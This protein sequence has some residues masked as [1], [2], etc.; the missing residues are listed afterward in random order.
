MLRGPFA[1]MIRRDT[2]L[3][4][5][6]ELLH[7]CSNIVATKIL[8]ANI[9]LINKE[10]QFQ[11]NYWLKWCFPWSF[12]VTPF[13]RKNVLLGMEVVNA[14]LTTIFL[15]KEELVFQNCTCKA[16][17]ASCTCQRAKNCT[18]LHVHE[19]IVY[20]VIPIFIKLRSRN[21][22][23]KYAEFISFVKAWSINTCAN[24]HDDAQTCTQITKLKIILA[25]F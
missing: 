13:T 1:T 17:R 7:H 25:Q 4:H 11:S 3:H 16:K 14:N 21:I 23:V 12:R 6:F 24:T 19:L 5:C 8:V 20:Q 22:C 9:S 15:V 18:Q 10:D 2:A